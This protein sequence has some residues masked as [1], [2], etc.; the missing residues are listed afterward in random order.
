MV[1]AATRAKAAIVIVMPRTRFIVFAS[2]G[3]EE[4][5]IALGPRIRQGLREVG[6][7]MGSDALAL[8]HRTPHLPERLLLQL[9]YAFTR[10]PVV[11]PD[12]FQGPLLVV[13]QPEALPQDVR[14]DR[15]ERRQKP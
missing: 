7:K 13:H 4:A 8:G 2:V 5:T 9:A 6:T 1:H 14:F 15:L 11:V 10:E 12:L 3:E